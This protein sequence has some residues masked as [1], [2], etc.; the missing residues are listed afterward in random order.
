MNYVA[1][2]TNPGF[3]AGVNDAA[4]LATAPMF[5]LLN[6]DVELRVPVARTLIA[7]L[8]RHDHVAIVGG[9]IR[10]A[11][12]TIQASAR[13]FP[14]L[15][16]AFGGRTSWLTRISPGNPLSRRNLSASLGSPE[17]AVKVD[18]VS[19]A[20][21]MIRADVFRGLGGFDER[22]FM[23]WE[24]SDLCLRA[25][26]SGWATM[27]EP[28]VE[29]TAPDRAIEPP[30]TSAI[31][32]RVS[33]QRLPSLLE[34]RVA[35][36]ARARAAC[37]RRPGRASCDQAG[38]IASR[39][40][41]ARQRPP[42]SERL[43]EV[44]AVAPV[45]VGL[46]VVTYNSTE[47]VEQCLQA[48]QGQ[49]RRPDRIV[50][51]DSGSTDGTLG[52]VESSC[53]RIGLTVEL[54]PFTENV[55][56]AVA[57]NRAVAELGG[58]S[59]V[60]LLNPDAFPE[61]GWLT[62]LVDAAAAHPEAASFASRLMAAGATDVLDGAGDTFHVSGLAWRVG[63]GQAIGRV[64]D[65]LRAGPVF[66]ACAAAALYRRDDWQ[67]VGGFDERFFCYVED[68]DLGSVCNWSAGRAATFRRL[69]RTMWG[70]QCRASTVRFRSITAIEISS[71]RS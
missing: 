23:Y 67:R 24:D 65:A 11:D 31:A 49:T 54:M 55:G 36:R 63:H 20:F 44:A 43:I 68:V 17:T 13:R 9:R 58:C 56:F 62:A 8:E 22:F 19:G 53:A 40:H 45:T 42:R 39:V 37:R 71:G 7:S 18:W 14:D 30:C 34:A 29:V 66:S 41:S 35:A 26:R 6:P 28:G 59:L 5:L 60:A 51:A 1:R 33:R 70:Q 38:R 25:L 52:L 10:E 46:V 69:L 15:S 50:I 21:T 32:R 64:P 2:S 16:T 47:Q 4:R 12:G 48:I 61:A 27:Y 3:G 57:N